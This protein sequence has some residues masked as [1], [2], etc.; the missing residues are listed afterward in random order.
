[1]KNLQ[2]NPKLVVV[3]RQDLSPGYQAVQAGHALIQFQHEYPEISKKWHSN[4]NY[5]ALLS[6]KDEQ[7]LINLI[8]KCQ[9][10]DLKVSVFTE[11][12]IDNQ[13]TAI[14]IEP[15]VETQKLCSNLPLAL[16]E[17]NDKPEKV[18]FHFNKAHLSNPEIPMWV[19]KHKGQTHYVHHVEFKPGIGFKTKETPDNPHT[20]GSIVIKGRLEINTKNNKTEAIVH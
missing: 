12:D 2:I 16:K 5:L 15:S 9:S 18:V 3:T 19:I 7:S 8:S 17:R 1:M 4:S 10:K 14:T 20:K 13:V 6:T 11:P